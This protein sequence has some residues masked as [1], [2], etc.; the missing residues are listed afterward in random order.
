M[1]SLFLY[2]FAYSSKTVF[3]G[4]IYLVLPESYLVD[5]RSLSLGSDANDMQLI[6]K[7]FVG[8]SLGL[9]YQVKFYSSMKNNTYFLSFGGHGSL[10]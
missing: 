5:H 7:C 8:K 3:S 4:R 6:A 9:E 1:E 2:N 10:P